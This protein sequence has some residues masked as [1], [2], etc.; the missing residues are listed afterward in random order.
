V[1]QC[2]TLAKIHNHMAQGVFQNQTC[3]QGPILKKIKLQGAKPKV[4]YITGGKTLLTILNMNL[5]L[6]PDT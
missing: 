6:S 3:L 4:S 2:A 5:I 1:T